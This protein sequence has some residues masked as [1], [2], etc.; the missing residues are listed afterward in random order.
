MTIIHADVHILAQTDH[1]FWNK[2]IMD[3]GKK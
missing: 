3:S 1:R 2:V